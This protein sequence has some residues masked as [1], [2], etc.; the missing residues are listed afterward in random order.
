MYHP[1][2]WCTIPPIVGRGMTITWFIRISRPVIVLLIVL[3]P[4]SPVLEHVITI[5]LVLAWND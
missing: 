5:A 1:S 3:L 2:V 4:L